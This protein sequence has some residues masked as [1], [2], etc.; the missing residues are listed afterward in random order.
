[1]KPTDKVVDLGAGTGLL[2]IRPAR[3]VSPGRVVVVDAST[4]HLE[5]L[6]Q[7]CDNIGA[8][9]VETVAARLERLPLDSVTFDAGPCA[10]PRF[11]TQVTLIRPSP[12]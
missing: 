3:A 11:D 4:G 2:T 1:M 5:R 8:S 12:R 6:R 9:N 7:N 10:A